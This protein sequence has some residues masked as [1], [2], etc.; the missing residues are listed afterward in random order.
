MPNCACNRQ[1]FI[2]TYV[3]MWGGFIGRANP[4]KLKGKEWVCSMVRNVCFQAV[5]CLPCCDLLTRI[6]CGLPNYRKY[7]FCYRCD[8]IDSKCIR[9]FFQPL[10]RDMVK[11]TEQKGTAPVQA[12]KAPE[13]SGTVAD[14]LS[15]DVQQAI[16]AELGRRRRKATSQ[17]KPMRHQ[18][19]TKGRPIGKSQDIES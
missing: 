6:Q 15:K 18:G 19:V 16:A 12:S 3:A 14:D 10:R 2:S 8:A 4:K 13:D 17:E 11:P 9:K 5:A 7:K 1:H